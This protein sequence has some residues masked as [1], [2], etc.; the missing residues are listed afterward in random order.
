MFNPLPAFKSDESKARYMASYDA[1]LHEWPVSYEELD[2]PTRRLRDGAMAYQDCC[3]RRREP[4]PQT[5]NRRPHGG[6]E[7]DCSKPA[8]NGIGEIK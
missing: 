8:P 6:S 5:A 7:R 2:L 1:V 3:L 4:T